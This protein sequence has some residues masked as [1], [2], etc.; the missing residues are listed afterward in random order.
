MPDNSMRSCLECTQVPVGSTPRKTVMRRSTP[1]SGILNVDKPRGMTSHDVVDVIRRLAGQRRVGHA[2]TLDPMATGVLLV[3][4]GQATRVAEYLM[5]SPKR[6]RATIVFG[7]ATDTFDAEGKIVS[8]GGRTDFAREEIEATLARFLGRIEQVPPMYSALKREGQTLH[9]LARQGKTVERS[10]R[11]VEI[12]EIV[13]LAWTPPELIIEVACSPGTYLRSLAHDLGQ[14]LGSGAHLAALVRLSSGRF[15]LG[16]A[17]SLERL[18]EAFG[19]GQE[20]KYLIPMDEAL[21]DWPALIVSMEEAR[22]IA[23]GQAVHLNSPISVEERA[24]CRSYGP[25]GQFLAIMTYD[26]KTN[27]WRPRKVFDLAAKS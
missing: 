8:E 26:A 25:D 3:C 20:T 18:E 5:A 27:L 1:L 23:Q 17:V 15:T 14:R 12:S 19:H 22:R 16:E 4:L 7:A 6:Y 11:W 13:V 21:L 9:R 10:P 24:L 2:G